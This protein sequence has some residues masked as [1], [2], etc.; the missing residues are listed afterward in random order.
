MKQATSIASQVAALPPR[1]LRILQV[2][3]TSVGGDWFLD[4]VT[5][6]ARLGHTVRTV[7]PREGPLPGRL[8]DAGIPVEIVSFQGKRLEQVPRVTAAELRLLRLVRA[9]RPDVI[10]AHLLK[11]VLSCRLG[12]LGHRQALRVSQVPGTVHLHSPLLRWLDQA[13]LS[14]D[15]VV[16]GSCQAI[17]SQYRAMGARTVAVSYYGCDVRK[18]DP[19]TTGEAFRREFG[20]HAVSQTEL[21]PEGFPRGSRIDLAHITPVV[22][23]GHRPRA[24]RPVLAGDRLAGADHYV[25]ARQRRLIEP[26]QQRTVQM[27]CSRHLGYAQG[28]AVA[29]RGQPTGQHGF[30]QVRMDDIRP[31]G[32]DE[33]QQAQLGSGYPR[34]LLQAFSLERDDLY[35][36]AGVAQPAWQRS[37]TGED[38]AHRVT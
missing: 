31:E 10:H 37:L 29:E 8:R 20:R 7:L 38:R 23:N 6:L 15:D 24:H 11:A 18:V 35:G 19:R 4:Q 28:L 25:V 32:T 3:A 26:P 17:A 30:Q 13:T 12:A 1:Q 27:N 21:T 33:A 14:R 16:I 9:F 36:N 34:H 2:T 22:A 5:G